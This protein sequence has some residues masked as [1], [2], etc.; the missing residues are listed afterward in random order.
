MPE[1]LAELEKMPLDEPVR[2]MIRLKY[3]PELSLPRPDLTYDEDY[4]EFALEMELRR[5]EA[6]DDRIAEMDSLQQDLVEELLASGAEDIVQ[7]WIINAVAATACVETILS[8]KERHDIEAISEYSEAVNDST[9]VKPTWVRTNTHGEM[10]RDYDFDGSRYSSR[11]F[12]RITVGVLESAFFETDHDAFMDNQSASRIFGKVNCNCIVPVEGTFCQDWVLEPDDG[13]ILNGPYCFDDHR[14]YCFLESPPVPEN[15]SDYVRYVKDNFHATSVMGIIG[16]DCLDSQCSAWGGDVDEQAKHSGVAPEVGLVSIN[17]GNGEESFAAAVEKMIKLKLDIANISAGYTGGT[18]APCPDAFH[19]TGRDP[20]SLAANNAYRDG[21]FF[22]ASAG[23]HN[24]DG[25]TTTSSEDCINGPPI[26]SWACSVRA[27]ATA[28]GV[29]A[30]GAFDSFLEFPWWQFDTS[31]FAKSY[32]SRGPTYDRRVKPDIMAPTDIACLPRFDDP[33][34][35]YDCESPFDDT[36]LGGT[37]AAAPVVAG[38]AADLKDWMIY[39]W[40]AATANDPGR[41]FANIINF[42]DRID[43]GGPMQF[44]NTYGAGRIRLRL[45]TISGLDTPWSY[46]TYRLSFVGAGQS[47]TLPLGP[48]ATTSPIPAKAKLIKVAAW[49]FE[50]ELEA[51]PLSSAQ[52]SR[53]EMCLRN[54]DTMETHCAQSYVPLGGST[55]LQDQKM[56][57]ILD[58]VGN[59]FPAFDSGHPWSLILTNTYMKSSFDIRQVFLTY[60]WEDSDRDDLDCAPCHDIRGPARCQCDFQNNR[61]LFFK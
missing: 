30:V 19:A 57:L 3:Q 27:P 47:Y 10:F 20:V 41:I 15:S 28:A 51:T 8:V 4:P 32:S 22:V 23:N 24:P 44:S 6:I 55:L 40:D 26:Y 52:P 5:A 48:N 56:H 25:D 33:H 53:F 39:N 21:I 17:R 11:G 2:V 29:L 37:S 18:Y 60:F 50:P 45:P 16:A 43:T 36:E 49:W 58:S 1:F 61:Y 54:T 7:L 12:S 38:A 31:G 42:G 14:D 34:R 13:C 46:R 9:V 35:F 59:S